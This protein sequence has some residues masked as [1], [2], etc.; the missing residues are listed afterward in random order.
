M[1]TIPQLVEEL[2]AKTPFLEEGL[3]RGLI[4]YSALAR[5]LKPAIEKKLYK[6][7]QTGAIVMALKRLANN[8]ALNTKGVKLNQILKSL[9]DIT[10]RS[11]I[12]EYAFV[13]SP[14][15]VEKQR[16]LMHFVEDRPNSFLTITDGVFETAFFASDNLITDIETTFVGEH[17]KAKLENL[18]SITLIIP[19]EATPVPGVYYAILK[20]LAWAGINFIEVVSSFTE[21]T[22]IVENKN[23]DRAF[24]VL[25]S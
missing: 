14:T 6:T 13:N 24:S 20:K 19:E 1:I 25:K 7:V 15:L 8:I 3:S 9:G 11:N 5:E 16:K 21:L 23:V 2:V 4:N 12:V 10:V 18:S 17:I 22:L